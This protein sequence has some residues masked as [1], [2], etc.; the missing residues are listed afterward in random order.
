MRV[1]TVEAAF[2]GRSLLLKAQR[3]E[4]EKRYGC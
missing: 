2:R 1:V 4:V 3:K